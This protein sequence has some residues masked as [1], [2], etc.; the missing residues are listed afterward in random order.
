M[1]NSYLG[2]YGPEWEKKIQ[3]KDHPNFWKYGVANLV[4]LDLVKKRQKILDV[5]C[6]TGGLTV[7]L[8]EH[9]QPNHII[10]IDPVKSMIKVA[11]QRAFQE[12][13]VHKT[14]FIVCDGRHLP[15][16]QACFHSLVSRG[17]AFV[18]LVPQKITLLEFKRVLKNE[19][20]LI[21]EQDNVQWKP[22]KSIFRGF[23]RMADGRV[24]YSLEDFDNV[25]N[26]TKIFYILDPHGTISKRIL[27]DKGF[28][29][30]GRLE[31][32]FP[33]RRIRTETIETRQSAVTHWPT[34]DEMRTLLAEEGYTAIEIF[35][36][37]LLMSLLL[38]GDQKVTRAMKKQ[39]ELFFQ[40]EKKLI[41]YINPASALT[42]IVKAMTP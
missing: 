14:D 35:G 9:A 22:G 2:Y 39:P 12:G 26:H 27:K 36:D 28:I 10:G 33:I 7:F 6:G 4:F 37:G 17:D 38:E 29:Q 19:A 23:E 42:V 3:N 18:F 40:I 5:G 25:R 31:R 24:A 32:K 15:F 30:T 21:I 34:V 20:T 13:L 16:G 8:A 11:R 1:H 41:R